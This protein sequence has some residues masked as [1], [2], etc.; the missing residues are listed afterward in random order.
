MTRL[1]NLGMRIVSLVLC[2]ACLLVLAQPT[3]ASAQSSE[4]QQILTTV[5]HYSAYYSASVIGQL[6]NGTKVT[7]LGQKKSFYK[8]DCYDMKGY[9]AKSQIV[10]TEDDEYYVNCVEGSSETKVLT[11][12]DY[13]QALTMQHS[14]LALAKEQLGSRYVYGA[15]RPGA[16]DCSG[17][18]TYLYGQHSISI[19]RTASTQLQ[20]GVIIPREA[21]QVGDLIFFREGRSSTIATHVGIYVGENKMIHAGGVGVEYEDMDGVYVSRN[22]LCAR[23]IINTSAVQLDTATDSALTVTS[24]T[25]RTAG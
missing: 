5:V 13:A 15:S 23:R 14:L 8:V 12:T 9:I 24:V 18:T 20:D 7:V 22:Y 19:H 25:G 11:Y 16:F 21:L 17:L 2:L 4:A 3:A 1:Q 10:H 6:E